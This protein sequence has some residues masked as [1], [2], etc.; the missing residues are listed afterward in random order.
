[1]THDL[2][3]GASLVGEHGCLACHGT[4]KDESVVFR[5]ARFFT[6][7]RLFGLTSDR[8][9]RFAASS[10]VLAHFCLRAPV[11]TAG[12]APAR[13]MKKSR[14]C[15]NT[16]MQLNRLAFREIFFFVMA[17]GSICGFP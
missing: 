7:H 15:S 14:S 12:S 6:G 10:P 1:V 8:V 5:T 11:P 16:R 9:G 4:G 3:P 2:V 13:E 17:G